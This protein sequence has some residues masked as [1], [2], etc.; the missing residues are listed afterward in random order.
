M[1]HFPIPKATVYT[2]KEGDRGIV[3]WAVQRVCNKLGVPT[4]EDGVYGPQTKASVEKIQTRLNV[5]PDGAVG[6]QTQ[7]ALALYLCER[8]ERLSGLPAKLLRSKVMYESGGFLGA[9]NWSVAGGVDCG[10]TQR[11]VYDESYSDDAA[12]KRAFDA[13]YQ[14]DLSGDRV[15]EL[16]DIFIARPGVKGNRELAFRLAVLNHNY[17]SLADSISRVGISGLSTYY[18]SP[19]TWV[20]GFGLKFPDGTPIRTPLEW[21]QRYSLGNATHKEPGQACKLVTDWGSA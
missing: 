13:A 3:A 15:S 20:T 16:T 5:T 12:I 10:I 17:P 6:P 21:G 1:S 4:S 7:Q 2:V 18:R 9:V 19:Q 11:R 8:Q 14:L